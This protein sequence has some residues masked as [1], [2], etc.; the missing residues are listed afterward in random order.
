MQ[1][2]LSKEKRL[3]VL[4]GHADPVW[5]DATGR[6]NVIV[7]HGV[8]FNFDNGATLSSYPGTTANRENTRMIL[9]PSEW[10]AKLDAQA[11][12]HIRTIVVGC[13]KLDKWHRKPPKPRS[14]PPTIAFA[15]HWAC[16]VAPEAGN[17]WPWYSGCLPQL[18]QRFKVIGHGHPHILEWLAPQYEEMGVE[19]VW[20]LEEVFERADLLCF[21]ATSAGYEFAS[22]DRP[23]VVLNAPWYRRDVDFGLRFWRHAD[24]GVNVDEPQDLSGAIDYALADPIEQQQKRHAAVQYAYTYTDGQSAK[25]A[26]TA[27]LT[28]LEE[29]D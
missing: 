17:A 22:L 25:R 4:A 1:E 15:F 27:I 7:P 13:P 23:V 2:A 12:P 19:V 9:C 26:A 21:D 10:M 5:L 11:N 18:A 6:P 28:L 3:T 16:E 29:G 8:G 20:N 14:V 24:V